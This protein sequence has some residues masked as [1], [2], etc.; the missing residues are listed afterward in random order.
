[1]QTTN[2]TQ[3]GHPV[4]F[5]GDQTGPHNLDDHLIFVFDT[6]FD[7]NLDYQFDAIDN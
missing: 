1:M 2:F 3:V 6:E 5:L 4:W 7:V